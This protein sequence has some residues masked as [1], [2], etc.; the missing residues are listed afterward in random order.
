M[1]EWATVR[2]IRRAW[3]FFV[4]GV[5]NDAM[6]DRREVVNVRVFF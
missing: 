1:I 4:R 3:I 6:F 5:S 2:S